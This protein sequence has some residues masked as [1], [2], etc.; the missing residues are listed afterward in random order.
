MTG[1][2]IAVYQ[3]GRN[4]QVKGGSQ[5]GMVFRAGVNYRINP[6]FPGNRKA[7]DNTGL[8]AV[9]RVPFGCPVG[10][11]IR[12]PAGVPGRFSEEHRGNPRFFSDKQVNPVRPPFNPQI[13]G[14]K[15]KILR[16]K[17]NRPEAKEPQAEYNTFQHNFIIG[18]K[19]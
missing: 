14:L 13:G 16:K 18:K 1:I 7:P 6:V 17:L 3:N 8:I 19:A 11:I 12:L 4:I 2:F 15:G 5:F 10:K 9:Y